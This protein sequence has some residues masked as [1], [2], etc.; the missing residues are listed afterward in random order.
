[1]QATAGLA[2][3]AASTAKAAASPRPLILQSITPGP[4]FWS[5]GVT[6][7]ASVYLILVGLVKGCRRGAT[8]R[9]DGPHAQPDWPFD[10]TTAV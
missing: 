2:L 4:G 5:S 10:L 8:T 7:L 3:P 9:G 1:M 6:P